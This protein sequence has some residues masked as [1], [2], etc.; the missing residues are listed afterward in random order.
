M[1]IIEDDDGFGNYD[2]SRR[3]NERNV[4]PTKGK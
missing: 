1:E 4:V 3:I 2:Q